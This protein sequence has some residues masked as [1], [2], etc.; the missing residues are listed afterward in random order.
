MGSDIARGLLAGAVRRNAD[1][2]RGYGPVARRLSGF[3]SL[4]LTVLDVS[5]L[6]VGRTDAALQNGSGEMLWL[7]GYSAIGGG[8]VLG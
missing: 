7:T 3:R 5:K 8:D 2:R 6:P 4:E 1:K